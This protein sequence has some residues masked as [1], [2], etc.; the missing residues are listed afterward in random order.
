M[1]NNDLSTLRDIHLPSSVPWWPPAV[2]WWLV[3]AL[4]I[5]LILLSII[6][7]R[8]YR[9][10]R[11]KRSALRELQAIQT[12]FAAHN[13]R[14]QLLSDVSALLRRVCISLYPRTTAASLTGTAWLDLLNSNSNAFNKQLGQLLIS[15][16]Y[17]AQSDY[18]SA[19]LLTAV[20]HWLND[21]PKPE[22]STQHIGYKKLLSWYR[23]LRQKLFPNREIA[24]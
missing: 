8:A 9:Q 15:G 17:Q 6:G 18:D 22:H 2:G 20:Q 13:N 24:T 19:D 21:L 7:W 12:A 14:Q 1:T 4:I 5:V 16:P 10:Q 11:L 23:P 3:L